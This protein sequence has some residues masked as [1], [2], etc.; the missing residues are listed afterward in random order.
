M[1]L[2][3]CFV[4]EYKPSSS[5]VCQPHRGKLGGGWDLSLVIDR[6]SFCDFEMTNDQ[7]PITND[8]FPPHF[9]SR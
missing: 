2:L 6:W 7:Q 9:I 5:H 4:R 3:F 1:C 8:Q